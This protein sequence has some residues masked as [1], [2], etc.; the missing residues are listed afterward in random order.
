MFPD[1]LIFDF[2]GVI[3]DSESISLST[4]QSALRAYGNDLPLDEVRRRYLGKAMK[5]IK[6]DMQAEYS[7]ADWDGFDVHWNAI[8]FDRF[9]KELRPLPGLVALL[10]RA[11]ARGLPYCIASSGSLERI[12]FALGAMGLGAR[13]SHVFSAEQVTH[14]KPA[15]DLFLHAAKTIGV[16]PHRCL[17]LED[18][19]YGIQAAKSAG[20]RA[21]GFVGGAHLEDIRAEH[22]DLLLEH[23]AHDVVEHLNEITFEK[24]RTRW[25]MPNTD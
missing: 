16:P 9:R 13:F 10:D 18:S 19:P 5:Q 1:L 15:P 7:G 14:G 2:D 24:M 20:M 25:K 11:E 3:A 12:G 22:R 6:K 8:L 17:V 21:L 4:L 23:G